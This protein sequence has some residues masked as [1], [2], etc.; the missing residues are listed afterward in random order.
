MTK[1]LL[2][3]LLLLPLSVSAGDLDGKA[4]S[5]K[6]PPEYTDHEYFEFEAGTVVR[7]RIL[8][9]ETTAVLKEFNTASYVASPHR[10][11]WEMGD[12]E[13]SLNRATLELEKLINDR[14][15]F[16]NQKG[17]NVFRWYCE[18]YT[19]ISEFRSMLEA[20][21]LRKQREI[22]EQMSNNKI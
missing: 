22:D 6:P 21:K 7:W 5:C 18:V 4:I 9:D 10:I 11:T 14:P 20:L 19:S 17:N 8:M 2:A 13:W 3:I 15:F 1:P 16:T 12:R